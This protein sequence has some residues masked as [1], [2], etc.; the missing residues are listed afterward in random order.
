MATVMPVSLHFQ[1]PD[2][3]VAGD[4]DEAGAPGAA[5]I[6]GHLGSVEGTFPAN[7]VIQG[8]LRPDA[9]SL[10]KIANEPIK[11]TQ[12]DDAFTAAQVVE[13]RE[14]RASRTPGLVQIMKVV[15]DRGGTAQP[16][17]QTQ[18]FLSMRELDD[19]TKRAVVTIQLTATP[20]Q[21]STVI[22]DFEAFLRTVRTAEPEEVSN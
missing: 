15:I 17:I 2:G 22:D 16:L 12:Q 11:Q 9:A 20:S 4:P 21:F 7:I 10:E 19:P 18:V 1:L 13:R 5:F 6:A 8:E 14:I 3:W